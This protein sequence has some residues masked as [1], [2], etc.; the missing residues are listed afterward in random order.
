M[1]FAKCH[2]LPIWQL[3]QL[4]DFEGFGGVDIPYIGY[5]QIQLQILGVK[6]YN[7]DILVLIQKDSHY[8]E[9]VPVI[10]G[11]LPIKDVIQ[12]ATLEELVKLGD[13]WEVGTLDSL[14]SARI[15]QLE[16]T[17][18]INQVD[19]YVRLTQKVTLAPMQVHK[20][21]GIAKIPIL[22]KRLNVMTEPLPVREAIEGV[23]AIASYETFKQGGNRVTIGLQNGT[24]E[25]IILKKGTKV[26]HVTAANI[27]PPMLAPDPSIDKSELEYIMQEHNKEDVPEYKIMNS[28]ENVAKPK[29]MLERLDKLFTKLDLSGIQDWSEDLQQEVHGLMVEYQHL[30]ALNDLELGRTSKVKD[31]I[32]LS[33]P[34]P[35]KDRY[36][37]ENLSVHGPVP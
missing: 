34:V 28:G 29:P 5:T 35:F 32:K 6:D 22:S 4:L 11:T 23:E 20:T 10:L 27:V 30:F 31:E 24:Q 21:V 26:A 37:F 1:A 17:P 19:H 33:N 16:N 36:R 18:M 14:V 15:A 12:S 8:L 2:N 3:Q 7:K 25:K 9:Q 13:A